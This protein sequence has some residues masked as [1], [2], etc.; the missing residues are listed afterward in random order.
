MQSQ[1]RPSI[2]QS[3]GE[4]H[5]IKIEVATETTHTNKESVLNSIFFEGIGPHQL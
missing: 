1:H 4:L 2:P 3:L 5:L